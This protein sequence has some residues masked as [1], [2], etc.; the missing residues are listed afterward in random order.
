MM[1]Y[2]QALVAFTTKNFMPKKQKGKAIF[3]IIMLV[4]SNGY[5]RRS[6]SYTKIPK[7]ERLK[8]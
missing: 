2:L 8:C 7:V 3:V 6:T 1:T 5:L 4:R